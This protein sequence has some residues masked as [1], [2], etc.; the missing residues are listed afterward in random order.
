MGGFCYLDRKALTSG[1]FTSKGRGATGFIS[2]DAFLF[3][4]TVLLLRELRV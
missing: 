2:Q 4:R 1:I 3:Q